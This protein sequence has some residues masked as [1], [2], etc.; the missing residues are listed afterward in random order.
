MFGCVVC[1]HIVSS[2]VQN[3]FSCMDSSTNFSWVFSK[4]NVSNKVHFAVPYHECST[5]YNSWAACEATVSSYGQSAVMC[6]GHSTIL[7]CVI[8]EGT[9]STNCHIAIPGMD[10]STIYFS[11][12]VTESAITSDIQSAVMCWDSSTIPFNWVVSETTVTIKCQSAVICK[13]SSTILSWSLKVLFPVKSRMLVFAWIP[14]PTQMQVWILLEHLLQLFIKLLL[15]LR[16]RQLR[17]SQSS[18]NTVLKWA[19]CY[20]CVLSWMDWYSKHSLVI[21]ARIRLPMDVFIYIFATRVKHQTMQSQLW[22]VYEY[23][24]NIS[25]THNLYCLTLCSRGQLCSVDFDITDILHS[26]VDTEDMVPR[27]E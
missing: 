18:T 6:M 27:E 15:P 20:L 17:N 24:A 8:S 26:K 9:V 5:R 23:E 1:E 19:V 25:F 16:S 13:Y 2:E 12:V 4:C 7:S 10:S 22:N 3:T 14:P 11:W 21:D